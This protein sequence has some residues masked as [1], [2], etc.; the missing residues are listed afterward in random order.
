[1]GVIVSP[2]RRRDIKKSR[3][4]CGPCTRKFNIVSKDHGCTQKCD[5]P[6]FDRKYPFWANLLKKFEVTS[7]SWNLVSILIWICRIQWW[8]SRFS[9]F[10]RKY[11]FWANLVPKLEIYFLK[12]NLVPRLIWMCKN[13]DA[14]FPCF[15]PEVSF[16]GKFGP[17]NQNC[18]SV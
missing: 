12:W 15:P 11:H 13:G 6:I 4:V 3:C 16:W 5:F 2:T 18:L 9:V 7:L 8:C 17:K 10:N 14:H 1:M